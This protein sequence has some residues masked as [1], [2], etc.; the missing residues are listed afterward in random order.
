MRVI[1]GTAKGR[2]LAPPVDRSIRPTGD[3]VKEALFS[4]LYS[5]AG[6]LEGMAILDLFAGSGALGIEALSRGADRCL[7]VD[8]S[9]DACRLIAANL[10]TTGLLPNS[11]VWCKK[12]T[13]AL[14]ALKADGTAFDLVLL[15]P[16]YSKGELETALQAIDEGTAVGQT[17]LVAV[18]T[19]SRDDVP[20]GL[21]NLQF[22]DRRC[23][24]ST[25]LCFYRYLRPN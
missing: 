17:A 24:G 16:P 2:P 9:R 7:F 21:R 5:M 1:S 11:S 8:S 18:E 14:A 20:T 3:R 4:I 13:Q 10:A 6:P 19:S 25:A 22:L 12:A 23:Y 15:D